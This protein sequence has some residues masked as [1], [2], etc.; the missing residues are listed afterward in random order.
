M[1]HRCRRFLAS[2]RRSRQLTWQ[3]IFPHARIVTDPT[4]LA[5]LNAEVA[6]R[7]RKEDAKVKVG[8]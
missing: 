4:K 8:G 1:K 3:E 2:S 5:L 7:K 6:E